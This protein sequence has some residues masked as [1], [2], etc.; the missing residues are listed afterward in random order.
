M[1]FRSYCGHDSAGRP[2]IVVASDEQN[3]AEWCRISDYFTLQSESSRGDYIAAALNMYRAATE[4]KSGP[5]GE[6]HA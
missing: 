2:Q 1:K 4:D 5:H 6:M 3:Y